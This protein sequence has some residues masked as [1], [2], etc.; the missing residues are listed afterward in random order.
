MGLCMVQPFDSASFAPRAPNAVALAPLIQAMARLLSSTRARTCAASTPYTTNTAKVIAMK[1]ALNS[2]MCAIALSVPAGTNC[3]TMLW[4][5]KRT[6]HWKADWIT[7]LK[8]DVCDRKAAAGLGRLG[9]SA[10]GRR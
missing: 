7:K 4:E 3:G 6:K 9:E 8:R 1:T 2:S 5:T 10:A